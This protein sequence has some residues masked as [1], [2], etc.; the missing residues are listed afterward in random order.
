MEDKKVEKLIEY[1]PGGMSEGMTVEDIA[2]KHG[3]DVSII[4]NQI[5]MGV[6]VEVEHTKDKNVA[7]EIAKDHLTETPFYYDYLEEMEKEFKENY[8]EDLERGGMEDEE[9]EEEKGRA[10]TEAEAIEFLKKNPNPSDD[11][12]HEYCEEKGIKVPTMEAQMY[13]LATAHVKMSEK[14]D[15]IED[16]IEDAKKKETKKEDPKKEEEEEEEEDPEEQKKKSEEEKKKAEE[17]KK[18]EDEKKKKGMKKTK[19]DAIEIKN[20][21]LQRLFG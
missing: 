17:L 19:K 11:D 14:K 9:A 18:E 13:K 2:K 6:K 4:N 3:V 1:I 7:A 5:K 20:E 10:A 15:S 21:T 8:K 12:L 16:D